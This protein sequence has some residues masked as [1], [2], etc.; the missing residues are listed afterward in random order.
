[1]RKRRGKR[2]SLR[3]IQPSP[4]LADRHLYGGDVSERNEASENGETA[5]SRQLLG[6]PLSTSAVS[7]SAPEQF[8]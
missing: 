5:S 4:Q 8:D 2:L 7:N 3:V 6:S 1:M